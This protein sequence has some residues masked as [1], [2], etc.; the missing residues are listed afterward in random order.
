MGRHKQVSDEAVLSAARELFADK[1]FGVSTR[2]IARRAGVSEAVLYLRHKTK[3]DLFYAAMIPP[4]VHLPGPSDAS[5][6]RTLATDLEVL[7]DQILEYFRRAMPVI[8]QL[9]STPSF[10]LSDVAQ[11]GPEMPLHRLGEAIADCLEWH[12]ARG[13]V[14]TDPQRI[15]AATLTLLATLHSVA[16]FERM[17]LHRAS[18]DRPV[19]NDIV[20]LIAEGLV[21]PGA[22]H[23]QVSSGTSP[24]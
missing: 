8:L 12:R 22:A 19:V 17:G 23:P 15:N 13:G 2:E 16:L 7:A 1:G 6:Q 21:P 24:V 4:P 18:R 5:G 10:A 14:V 3:L 9:V 20:A 11:A